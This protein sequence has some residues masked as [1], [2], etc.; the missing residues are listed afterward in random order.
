MRR[1]SRGSWV[2]DITRT[3]RPRIALREENPY[4]FINVVHE[5][6]VKLM[7]YISRACEKTHKNTSIFWLSVRGLESFDYVT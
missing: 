1:I 7:I 3:F 5:T 6:F 4:D 2:R